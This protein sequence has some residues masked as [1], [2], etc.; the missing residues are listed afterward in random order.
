MTHQGPSPVGEA[1]ARL[2]RLL[3]IERKVSEY[4]VE[5]VWRRVLGEELA[6]N[7]RP[8]HLKGGVL[9]VEARSAAW[10]S[11]LSLMRERLRESLN[12]ELGSEKIRQLRFR[13]GTGFGPPP[14]EQPASRAPSPGEVA[15][16]EQELQAEGA[17]EGSRLA[18]RALAASRRKAPGRR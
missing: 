11:E 12:K 7:A 1:L 5:P 8:L 18:A 17:S 6:R 13:L 9:T 15:A 3:D 14:G 10:M 4:A 16:A 2:M